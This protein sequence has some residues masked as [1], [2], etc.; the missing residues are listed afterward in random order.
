LARGANACIAGWTE[1]RGETHDVFLYFAEKTK[2]QNSLE[3]T[4]EI[5][6]KIYHQ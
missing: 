5:V 6:E 3:H 2:R 4:K 1:T